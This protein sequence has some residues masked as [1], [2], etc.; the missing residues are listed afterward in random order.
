M[1]DCRER[2]EKSTAAVF[3]DVNGYT[4]FEATN[5]SRIVVGVEFVNDDI[6]VHSDR[7]RCDIHVPLQ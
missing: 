4:A 1:S 7:S 3:G 2:T 5:L 6:A